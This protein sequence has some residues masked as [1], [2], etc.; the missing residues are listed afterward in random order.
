MAFSISA[1]ATGLAG[2]S[3]NQ[4][5]KAKEDKERAREDEKTA[6]VRSFAENERAYKRQQDAAAEE[7]A[8]QEF[9]YRIQGLANQAE[10]D[11][12]T[13]KEFLRKYNAMQNFRGL[14]DAAD[15]DDP[16]TY[17]KLYT[18]G[19]LQHTGNGLMQ[20]RLDYD[21]ATKT[22]SRVEYGNNGLKL[23]SIG[24]P[25]TYD[26]GLRFMYGNIN[27]EQTFA[28]RESLRKNAAAKAAE[29]HEWQ[30]KKDYEHN[31]S[32]DLEGV[33]GLNQRAN[34]MLSG[35]NTLDNTALGWNMKGRYGEQNPTST[36]TASKTP[37]IQSSWGVNSITQSVMPSLWGVES[38]GRHTD[39]AGRLTQSPAGALG[40]GQLMPGTIRD[41]G[42]GVAPPRDNSETENMRVSAQYFQAMQNRYG[43]DLD[44]ALAAYNAGPGNVDNA[45]KVAKQ[46]GG[47][48]KKYLPKPSETIPYIAK[49]KQNMQKGIYEQALGNNV[50]TA[51][52]VRTNADSLATQAVIDFKD[53]EG[54]NPVAV[55][56]AIIGASRHIEAAVTARTVE[57]RNQNIDRA[58]GVLK[59]TFGAVLPSK[60]FDVF[61][62]DTIRALAG[63]KSFTSFALNSNP[64]TVKA[65]VAKADG[66]L[67]AKIMGEDGK[68]PASK[69]AAT[70]QA[71]KPAAT[72][73]NIA[74]VLAATTNAPK[75]HRMQLDAVKKEIGV[76]QS[77]IKSGQASPLQQAKLNERLKDL[78][79]ALPDSRHISLSDTVGA[80]TEPFRFKLQTGLTGGAG[81]VQSNSP[82]VDNQMNMEAR[83]Q[84]GL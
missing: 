15:K 45:I 39:S 80:V 18:E 6:Y 55:K 30:I 59:A 49:V 61:S 79:K 73:P 29:L 71:A 70:T 8:G 63:D 33:K 28:D 60:Q 11:S 65:G 16:E 22:F 57:E 40:I 46:K 7:R 5:Q 24:E 20:R 12:L 36:S 43:G 31:Q 42:F 66:S 74:T 17:A 54:L 56:T 25:M 53:F 9:K 3:A 83:K 68:K 69:P 26:D 62:Q 10:Q 50:A 4:L 34:T 32:L 84:L 19:V 77:A 35:Q 37:A 21:P 72:Q 75:P 52:Q 14:M 23:K 58:N 82:A 48:W 67:D 38:G 27:P 78:T 44:L 1:L 47:D 76:I 51:N 64:Q 2:F 13:Q 81:S 41:P